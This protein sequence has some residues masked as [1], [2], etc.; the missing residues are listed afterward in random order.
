MSTGRVSESSDAASTSTYTQHACHGVKQASCHVCMTWLD[1]LPLKVATARHAR[2]IKSACGR[3]TVAD[4]E[5]LHKGVCIA[6]VL[7]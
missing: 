6:V 7:W 3:E 4:L 1:L 5:A 2:P